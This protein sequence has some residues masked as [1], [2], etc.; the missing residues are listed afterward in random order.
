MKKVLFA[1]TALVMTAGVA[2]AEVAV[3]GNARMGVIYDGDDAQFSSRARVVFDL[4]GETETGLSFGASFRADNSIGSKNGVAG[5]TWISGAYG[6]LTMGDVASASENAIGNLYEVGYTQGGFGYDLE[7]FSYLTADGAN[8]DQ[9]PNILYT[10]TYDRF[11]IYASASDGSDRKWSTTVG[12]NASDDIDGEDD[13]VAYSVAGKYD[14]ETWWI[15]LGYAKHD[16]AEEVSVG[17][18]VTYNGFTFKGAYFDYND[19]TTLS[20][21]SSDD[22]FRDV[23][24]SGVDADGNLLYEFDKSYGLSAEYSWDDFTVGAF[25]R[26]DEFEAQVD[27]RSD[28]DYDSWGLGA[29]YDLGGGA[30]LAGGVI[31]TD[32]LDDTVADMGIRFTF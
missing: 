14:A 8:L 17:A 3:S 26:R 13:K 6:K 28:E 21:D 9:G 4:A 31:D 11:S 16:D 7:E 2:S 19:R 12:T 1:T 29:E 25:W 10:Y 18:G 23:I 22:N 5:S 27:D 30:I 15:G 20:F 24:V 32:Y